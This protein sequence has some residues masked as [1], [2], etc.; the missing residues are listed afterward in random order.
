M[1]K[2]MERI[3]AYTTATPGG[4]GGV[5]VDVEGMLVD[6]ITVLKASGYPKPEFLRMADS[7]WDAVAVSIRIPTAAKH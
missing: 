6:L 1:A 7:T 3:N 2:G 5:S 4:R